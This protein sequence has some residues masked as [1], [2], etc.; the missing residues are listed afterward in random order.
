M[1][2]LITGGNGNIAKMIKNHLS[3]EYEIVSPSRSE[4]NV[5]NFNE[6]EN[7]LNGDI[8]DVLI[9]TAIS[10]G[11]RTKDDS[12]NVTHN[13]LLMLENILHF[14]EKF[15]M[16]INFDS[17]AIYD[18]STDI[19]NRREEDLFTVPTDHYGFSKYLIYKRSLQHANVYNLRIFNIFHVNE[20][21][22]RFIK[23]CFL[24]KKRNLPITIFEDKYFDFVY[25]ED[26]IKIVKHY[27]DHFA[28]QDKLDKTINICYEEKCKLSDIA[29]IIMETD[30]PTRVIVLNEE[31]HR[32]Y[33]GNGSKL[34]SLNLQLI[35]L[36]TGLTY[37]GA[38]I[39]DKNILIYTHMS[40][41]DI[42]DG[43]TVAQYNFAKLLEKM[44][45]TVR[46]YSPTGILIQNEIF[47]KYYDNDFPIDDDCVV[48]Y[49]EGTQGNPL[50]AKNVV[51]WMLSELGKNVP[52]EWL[53][54]WGKNELVYYF[55]SETKFESSPEKIGV[56]Y[57]LLSCIYVN[58][59]IENYNFP[60]RNGVCYTI[61]K[62]NWHKNGVSFFHFSDSFEITR[63]HTQDE[64]ID[65]FNKYQYF[66]SYDPCSFLTIMAAMC[67]CVSVVHPVQGLTKQQWIQTTV[68]GEYV[69]SK[70]I[71]NLY[72][73][74]YGNDQSEYHYAFSTL[75]LVKEQWND[76][77]NFC[78]EKK[79][80]PFIND[81]QNFEGLQNTIQNNYF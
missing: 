28:N 65:F 69:K 35:G 33:S 63:E 44:G 27:I 52:C 13:N 50:N 21:S 7:F 71:N 38:N 2:I 76:I 53:Y 40:H 14:S 23:S 24:S 12:G 26:F 19:L 31:L 8:Y 34:K 30:D 77:L 15:K 20:E 74:V 16:I 64:C 57:K 46:I 59:R 1:K 70:G 48:I 29:K 51:R 32:N 11:R 73:I 49:S 10:G 67:G 41:F 81:I 25:E 18:R 55:N 60:N 72:G 22:D 3:S 9:H 75:H 17:G 36:T 47:N 54:G 37:Y 80:I 39:N 43:G 62:S 42:K 78:K 56:V 61:R 66:I 79:I 45:Q 5:L 6:I 4:L 68:V 58:P